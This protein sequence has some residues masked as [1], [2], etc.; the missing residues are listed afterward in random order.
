MQAPIR[1][2]LRTHPFSVEYKKSTD[3]IFIAKEFIEN[4]EKNVTDIIPKLDH[5]GSF[6]SDTPLKHKRMRSTISLAFNEMKHHCVNAKVKMVFL[7]SEGSTLTKEDLGVMEIAFLFIVKATECA[8]KVLHTFEE[9]LDAVGGY[10]ERIQPALKLAYCYEV[11][12]AVALADVYAANTVEIPGYHRKWK[13]GDTY[14]IPS[15]TIKVVEEYE[16][17]GLYAELSSGARGKPLIPLIGLREIDSLRFAKILYGWRL[18]EDA[19]LTDQYYDLEL[20]IDGKSYFDPCANSLESIPIW[21]IANTSLRPTTRIVQK[22]GK[23]TIVSRVN[24]TSFP[25][26]WN[27]KYTEHILNEQHHLRF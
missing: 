9:F 26:S 18:R 4:V 16:G 23:W 14:D 8:S 10:D 22:S 5:A 1:D 11:Q 19:P 27:S 21:Y 24:A 13:V 20:R 15:G 12:S 6:V 7:N 17:R 25:I 3:M 2:A